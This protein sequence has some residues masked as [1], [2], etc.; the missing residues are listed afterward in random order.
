MS[1]F[2]VPY[3]SSPASTPDSQQRRHENKNPFASLTPDPSTTPAG[4]PPSS[5]NSFTPAGP[6]PSSA[7]GSSVLGADHRS[8]TS[9]PLFPGFGGL[10][11]E[12]IAVSSEP[13][14]KRPFRDG[15]TKNGTPARPTAMRSGTQSHSPPFSDPGSDG[16]DEDDAMGES[17]GEE[18]D[19]HEFGRGLTA[20]GIL[21][22]DIGNRVGSSSESTEGSSHGTKRSRNGQNINY[23]NEPDLMQ[24]AS[25]SARPDVLSGIARD[26]AERLGRASLTE[27]DH[28]LLGTEELIGLVYQQN[29][30]STISA[31]SEELIKLW[32]VESSGDSEEPDEYVL[33]IG[34]S[35]SASPASK[36]AFL[37][38]FLLSLHHRP[39]AKASNTFSSSRTTRSFGFSQSFNARAG[40]RV[41]PIPKVLLDWLNT[42][43]NPYPSAIADLQSHRPNPAT[44]VSF[45]D[46]ILSSTLRG[47]LDEVIRVLKM[48]DFGHVNRESPNG[49]KEPEYLPAQIGNIRRVMS[50]MV[51]ILEQ[52]PAVV[53]GDWDVGGSDWTLFRLR[54]A[55]ANA[56]LTIFAEGG[57][58]DSN[59]NVVPFEAD[60]FGIQKRQSNA[61][62]LT[63]AS[64]K[65]ESKVPWTIYQNLKALYDMFLGGTTEIVSFCQDWVEASI[66]LTAWW[67]GE[68]SGLQNQQAESSRHQGGF[69]MS[70]R[71]VESDMEALYLRRL[72]W[73]L[74]RA[75]D[76]ED[77]DAFQIN[78]LNP[79]EVG[80]ASAIVGNVQDVIG[81]LR[82]WSL[83]IAA[84]VVEIASLGGWDGGENGT[85]A[86]NGFNQSDLMVLSYGQPKKEMDRDAILTEY[87][88]ELFHRLRLEDGKGHAG[89]STQKKRRTREGW[90]IGIQI[91]GRVDDLELARTKIADLLQK[92]KLDSGERVDKVLAL[93]GEIGLAEEARKVAER[94]ADS[95]AET[96]YSYGEALL[97][98][99][100][101]HQQRKMKGV[102]D[103]LISFC[104]VQSIAYPPDSELDHH[105]DLLISSPRQTLT[106][107][108]Q[109]DFEAAEMLHLH[110]SGYAT[111][112]SFYNLRDEGIESKSGQQ[113]GPQS[114]MQK[115]Q[116]AAALVATI[117]SAGDNIHGGLY[118]ESRGA[119]VSVDGLLAL[120]GEAL[121]FINREPNPQPPSFI[122]SPFPLEWFSSTVMIT[123]LAESKRI[124][125]VSQA[126][127]VLKAIEDLE[128]VTSRVYSQC[129]EFFQSAISSGN[130]SPGSSP[131]ATLKKSMSSMTSSSGFSLIGSS[132]LGSQVNG[133]MGS[134]GVLVKGNVKRG[135]DWRRA[136]P[137]KV[138]GDH[139]LRILRLG[140][141]TEI[142]GGWLDGDEDVF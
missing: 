115:Q 24:R 14:G 127:D 132:V 103:L 81:L 64:R 98:Y 40:G 72:A 42:N 2:T 130:G 15:R 65:A 124:L 122:L 3:S 121:M 129:E 88:E 75:T 109:V 45:W 92:M 73:S 120:L 32:Q 56:D 112:R 54:V 118:D 7:F 34:P 6:P 36:A 84:A 25:S 21:S 76:D 114:A 13:V 9:R 68:E 95:I 79:V 10:Q 63:E 138:S 30:P 140:L 70:L 26:F 111:L 17:E 83:P 78:T 99:A 66:A 58:R 137:K 97:Y 119:I 20:D 4:P 28:M 52:C 116:A 46:I 125:S 89:K 107:L 87:A 67:D 104:L 105:L 80:L 57:D 5:A 22:T 74:D 91:L 134:S 123:P 12:D 101:A 131:R 136:L 38:N 39:L 27:S 53:N 113:S 50:R 117:N 96:S 31:A 110:L 128:T 93:C 135:W 60:K 94:Y 108:S 102:L 29:P 33:G 61:P 133:S 82:A 49:A 90:E 86:M 1:G 41:L 142:S 37:S 71:S 16:D 141:A 59:S 139:V 11:A 23:S 106:E 77:E 35:N 100:R 62:T 44:H 51:Q 69:D 19:L 8:T 55:Q 43:H 47:K 18:A 48:T 126:F 85:S